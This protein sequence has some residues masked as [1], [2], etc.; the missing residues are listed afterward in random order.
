MEHR[1]LERVVIRGD[2]HHGADG[3]HPPEKLVDEGNGDDLALTKQ[4]T[5]LP[6]GFNL[7]N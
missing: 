4:L 6:A 1:Q 5:V 2:A 7:H 3:L